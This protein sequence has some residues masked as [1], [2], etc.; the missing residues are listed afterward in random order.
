MWLCTNKEYRRLVP[1]TGGQ[2]SFDRLPI[3]PDKSHPVSSGAHRRSA[4]LY[5][6]LSK[7]RGGNAVRESSP[8]ADADQGS[9]GYRPRRR[10]RQKRPLLLRAKVLGRHKKTE[11]AFLSRFQLQMGTVGP[12]ANVPDEKPL[13]QALFRDGPSHQ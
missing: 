2:R 5:G 1:R 12:H 11:N 10:G 13:F 6:Y 9:A 7:G 3:R 4:S 8:V